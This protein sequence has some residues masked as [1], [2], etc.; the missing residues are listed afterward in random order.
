MGV[1]KFST[2][3]I[4]IQAEHLKACNANLAQVREAAALALQG[5]G[6]VVSYVRITDA[7]SPSLER[8]GPADERRRRAKLARPMR[9]ARPART[10]ATTMA[11]VVERYKHLGPFFV[12]K[13]SRGDESVV[14]ERELASVMEKQI[15]ED[16]YS[17]ASSD[18]GTGDEDSVPLDCTNWG[19]G[20]V[21][22]YF[23]L[24]SLIY[25]TVCVCL[26][27]GAAHR[28]HRRQ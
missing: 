22:V 12:V 15:R 21:C 3:S 20:L 24:A 25:L 8:T 16:Q 27:A 10:P 5:G 17:C 14:C 18:E 23:L 28:S 13:D 11:A 19:L 6:D 4:A 26:F 9:A 7:S 1:P 2:L